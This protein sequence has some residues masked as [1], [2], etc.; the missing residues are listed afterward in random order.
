M[1]FAV[2]CATCSLM[3]SARRIIVFLIQYGTMA[4]NFGEDGVIRR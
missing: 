2:N 1:L 4:R 3:S